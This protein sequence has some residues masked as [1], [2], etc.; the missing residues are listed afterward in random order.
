MGLVEP[1]V[2][3]IP[4]GGGC[5]E[6]L[7]RLGDAKRAFE[8]IGYGKV[9]ASA[10][11]AREL[12]LLKEADGV[13]MNRERLLA[14]AKQ[15]AL[16]MVPSWARGARQDIAVEGD[17]GY[18]LLKMG[19]YMAREGGFI[20]EYDVVIVER[21]AHV[22]SGGRLTGTQKVSEQYLLDL[23][24][25]AFLSLCGNAKTQERMQ[26]MLKSGKALRN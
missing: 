14:D 26:H 20:T 21:L 9:S 25:E 8:L 13:S 5:K 2:G 18:A 3:L 24:R 19:I 12:G 6:M 15:A 4:A 10:A 11:H 22:L 23:E 1:G 17:A 16:A 7:L